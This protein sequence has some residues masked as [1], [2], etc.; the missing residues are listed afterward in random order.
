MSP[1]SKKEYLKSIVKRYRKAPKKDKSKILEEFCQ[2]CGYHRKY[3]I[4][5]LNTSGKH[6]RQPRGKRG[7]KPV[8][9]HPDISKALKTIWIA[10]NLICSKR[11]KAAIPDWI[12]FYQ[13]EYGYLPIE[14]TRK[15]LRIS[16]ATIDRI[17]RPIKH[18]Y[19]GKGRSATKPG[20][21]L[22]YHIPIKTNQWDE[23][24]PGFLEA[25][26]VHHCGT[27]MAG[28]YAVTLDV[29]DIA[30]GWTEQR[31]TYGIGH[32]DI[33]EQ[34]KN[35]EEALPFPL[36][37]LDCDNGGE[38]INKNIYRYLT[39]RKTPAQFTRSR[40]YYKNDNAHVEAK[41]WT[42]VRQ[43]LGYRRF[44]NPAIVA[45]LNNLY[46][47]EWRLYHNFF[48][49]SVKLQAKERFA[50]KTIKHHDK[51]KTPYQRILAS[52]FVPPHTKL[53]LKNLF[54]TLNPF[55]LKKTIDQ[56]IAKIHQLAR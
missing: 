21:L 33:F 6:R 53:L 19:R 25:D 37:G 9:D 38:F 2:V 30:T 3:A 50:S 28:I 13:T 26:T 40:A 44:E 10:T 12:G 45:L 47:T 20:L 52:N 24:K 34:I 11:L 22:K 31:A 54:K 1:Q 43:W 14:V 4:A 55:K 18:L 5:K 8:Y 49:P 36:L 35:I 56:K 27:S 51:P 32:Y 42:H 39:H 23:S 7:P 17:L 48:I 41:N 46:K 16:P 15:I 29:V